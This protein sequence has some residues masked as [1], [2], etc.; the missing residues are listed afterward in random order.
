MVARGHWPYLITF[1]YSLV[2]CDF[3]RIK[4]NMFRTRKFIWCL[5]LIQFMFIS[6]NF[7]EF[8]SNKKFWLEMCLIWIKQNSILW[9]TVDLNRVY[10]E[11]KTRLNKTLETTSSTWL[12]V[13]A[14][15]ILSL[16]TTD[17]WWQMT[18]RKEG[19]AEGTKNLA[20]SPR[21]DHTD[22]EP[23][24]IGLSS[25]VCGLHPN[26]WIEP[27]QKINFVTSDCN[28]SRNIEVSESKKR[29]FNKN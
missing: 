2:K 19:Y 28:T 29:H 14:H 18:F 24:N 8:N 6:I 17:N 12:C 4:L 10:F 15:S 22:F 11:T 26:Y 27:A 9:Y 25:I 16:H 5:Y 20:Q 23:E 7:I 13:T 1:N 3:I 21:P